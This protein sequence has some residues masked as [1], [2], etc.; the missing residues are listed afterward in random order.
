MID[1]WAYHKEGWLYILYILLKNEKV[2]YIYEKYLE[3]QLIR[4]NHTQGHQTL[5]SLCFG[6]LNLKCYKNDY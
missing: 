2:N 4:V 1:K 6:H 5:V 3:N